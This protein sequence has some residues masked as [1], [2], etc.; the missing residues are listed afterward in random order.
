VQAATTRLP[1]GVRTVISYPLPEVTGSAQQ[2][3]STAFFLRPPP[4]TGV[5]WGVLVCASPCAGR[6]G[7][8]R[9]R[10]GKKRGACGT[11]FG[12]GIHGLFAEGHGVGERCL[13]TLGAALAAVLFCCTFLPYFSRA[14]RSRSG[15]RWQVL[16]SSSP[17][18]GFRLW[19]CTGCGCDDP[20]WPRGRL[21]RGARC[22][23]LTLNPACACPVARHRRAAVGVR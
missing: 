23:G 11:H 2:R 16:S 10:T 5:R 19:R 12:V 9:E 4:A 21:L 3:S 22:R 20:S 13:R 6:S 14:A 8:V 1:A 17:W 15:G 7:P 18:R